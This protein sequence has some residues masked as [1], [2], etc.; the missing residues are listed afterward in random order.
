VRLLD[1]GTPPPEV[2]L[3]STRIGISVA[4]ERPWRWRVA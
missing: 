3:V 2:P 4:R 1:D